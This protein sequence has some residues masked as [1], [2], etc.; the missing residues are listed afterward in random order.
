MKVIAKSF[1]APLGTQCKPGCV[2][3]VRNF[4]RECSK[5]KIK[6]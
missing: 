5:K 1:R 2:N 4:E 3:I 6:G